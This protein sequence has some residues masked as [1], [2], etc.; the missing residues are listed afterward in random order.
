MATN[1]NHQ[2]MPFTDNREFHR[3][4]QLF[5]RAEGVRYWN[6]EGRELLDGSSGLFCSAAGHGRTE[7]AEAVCKQLLTLDFTPH[8][9]RASP[10][11]FELAER[12]SDLLPAGLNKLF[13]TNSGSESVDSAMK[14]AL[15]YHRARGEAQRTRFVSREWAYHGVNFGGVALSG[16]MRNRQAFATGGLPHVSHMRHTWQEDQ[17]YQLGEP[18][19]GAD[20]ASDLERIIAMH[21][22]D[23]IAACFVEPI[24]GS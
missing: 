2:W 16:M 22:G 21:G 5:V 11:S 24:A 20:L 1:L 6:A 18:Q 3:A 14:I 8:F 4:P 12:L 10:L 19:Q 15:A 7:I 17:R 9:Q 13:F 23:S